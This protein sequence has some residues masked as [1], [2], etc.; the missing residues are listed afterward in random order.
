MV[1]GTTADALVW[2]ERHVRSQRLSDAVMKT[3]IVVNCS[4][5][6]KVAH[7][8]RAVTYAASVRWEPRLHCASEPV[9]QDNKINIDPFEGLEMIRL[10]AFCIC[11]A[12]SM[13][14]SQ[15]QAAR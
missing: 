10:H 9:M 12:V 1:E 15:K 6:E 5:L 7:K 11:S 4:Y 3:P 8:C 13:C 2:E 14:V